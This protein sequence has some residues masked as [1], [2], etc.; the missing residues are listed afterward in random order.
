MVPS[1][2]GDMQGSE[3]TVAHLLHVWPSMEKR[4]HQL[5]IILWHRNKQGNRNDCI[6][7]TP[8]L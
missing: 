2:R 5:S 3:G 4:S 7:I 8:S 6:I 1:Q